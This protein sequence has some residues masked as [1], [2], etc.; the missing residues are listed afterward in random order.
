MSNELTTVPTFTYRQGKYAN[1]TFKENPITVSFYNGTIS[2]TQEGY[3]DQDECVN[4]H[5]DHVKGLFKAILKHMPEA[6]HWLDK[7]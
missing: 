1:D 7:K 2:L 6:Q 5:P 3:Y 4:L